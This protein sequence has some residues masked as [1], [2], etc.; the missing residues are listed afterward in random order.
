MKSWMR[1]IRFIYN[2]TVSILSVCILNSI[3]NT[4]LQ[5]SKFQLN[6]NMTIYV[7]SVCVCCVCMLITVYIS[8]GSFQCQVKMVL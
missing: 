2:T 4:V 5:Y 6:D 1:L 8:W 7:N 3:Q